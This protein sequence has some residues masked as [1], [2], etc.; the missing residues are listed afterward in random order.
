MPPSV[1][2]RRPPPLRPGDAVAVV[3]PASPPRD[4]DRYRDG[5]DRLGEVYDLRSAWSAGPERGYLAASDGERA[6]AL[7]RAIEDPDVRGI[8]CVRG[9]Y[10]C[11]RLLDR[12]DYAAARRQ[13]TLL[14]GY[15]DVTALHLALYRHA[16]WTGLSGPVVTEWPVADAT[17]LE[18]FRAAAEGRAAPDLLGDDARVVGGSLDAPVSGPL[19]GGNLSVLTRLVGT[20]YCPSFEGAIL[21]IEDV[22]EAPYRIDRMLAHLRLAGAFSEAA[23]VV[24]GDF[25]DCTPDDA[26]SL[27]LDAV[28]DD[29]FGAGVPP[30]VAGLDY[31]HRLPR[32]TLP[33]GV[34]ATLTAGA[35]SPQLTLDQQAVADE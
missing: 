35:D 6:R 25:S 20:P 14:V 9:G 1:S 33:I 21:V 30:T 10:G 34:S 28:F 26:P 32:R 31:G 15:S 27:S 12:V 5:L 4:A 3:A 17:T 24:L 13:P 22:G 2:M 23:A 7:N 19:L 11:L 18:G 29:Y 8:V 16:G